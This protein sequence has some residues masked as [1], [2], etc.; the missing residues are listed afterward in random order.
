MSC[1]VVARTRLTIMLALMSCIVVARTR[2]T[3]T[4]HE[5]RLAFASLVTWHTALAPLLTFFPYLSLSQDT[6]D[7][8]GLSDCSSVGP[9]GAD[10]DRGKRGSV[11]EGISAVVYLA[12][13]GTMTFVSVETGDL[14]REIDILPGRMIVW[15]NDSFLHKVDV[16][17]STSPRVM[18]GVCARETRV[19]SVLCLFSW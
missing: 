12:G 4:N 16:G 14:E 11:V 8:L 9:T 10:C 3:I 13:G 2:L 17:D 7:P 19:Q 5:I 6:W 18:L 15:D 1:I